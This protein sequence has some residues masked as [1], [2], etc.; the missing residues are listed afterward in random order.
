M[1]RKQKNFFTGRRVY[2]LGSEVESTKFTFTENPKGVYLSS[3]SI[4]VKAKVENLHSGVIV[5][6]RHGHQIIVLYVKGFT[7]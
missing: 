7:L 3:V 5:L 1:V 6:E 4:L 2:P